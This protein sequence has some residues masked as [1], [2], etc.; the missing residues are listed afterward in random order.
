MSELFLK[1]R[2]P[3]KDTWNQV[4][5]AFDF[6]SPRATYVELGTLQ[7]PTGQTVVEG[8]VSFP[9]VVDSEGYHV[10]MILTD[11][12]DAPVALQPYLVN[13]EVPKHAFGGRELDS[14]L[15]GIIA[16]DDL[17]DLSID[18]GELTPT[19]LER[20]EIR[21][22]QRRE[23]KE[24][25]HALREARLAVR[26]AQFVLHSKQAAKDAAILGIN[27]AQD[28]RDAA[29]AVIQTAQ[30]AKAE[31]LG[32]KNAAQTVIDDSNSTREQKRNARENKS[33]AQI[34]IEEQQL[35]IDDAQEA[36]AK[37]LADISSGQ[38]TRDALNAEIVAARSVL[39]GAKSSLEV[40]R[41]S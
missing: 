36:K 3:S 2:L 24:K 18:A 38:Q 8:D 33:N 13:P 31:A 25:R 21:G 34:V 12:S 39:T 11:V 41:G 4:K 22:E 15:D 17:A 30:A 5:T 27:A 7:H 29:N 14:Q 20:A 26:E 28:A 16:P 19:V 35:L 32:T 40:V 1:L 37:A 6:Q 10:D 9:E 23:D